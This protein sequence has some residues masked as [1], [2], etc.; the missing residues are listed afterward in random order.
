M[1]HDFLGGL[2]ALARASQKNLSRRD[3][4]NAKRGKYETGMAPAP[5]Q[6]DAAQVR[7]YGGEIKMKEGSFDMNRGFAVLMACALILLN[8]SYS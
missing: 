2:C 8:A 5:A 3:A 7:K 1:N 6:I 4:K